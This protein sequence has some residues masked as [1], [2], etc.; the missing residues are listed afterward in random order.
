MRV[1]ICGI[2]NLDDAL[3]AVGNGADALGFNFY[4]KSP[5][6]VAPGKAGEIIADLPPFVTPVGVFVNAS[7]VHIDVVVKLAGLRAIQLHG[8]ESPEACLGHSVPVIRV[9]RVGQDFDAETM[10]SYLVDTFL[11]DTAKTGSYGGTGKTFDWSRAKDAK[12]FGRIILAGGLNPDNV[13]EA[14]DEVAPYAVDTSSGVEI[15]PGKK[16]HEKVRKFLE[17]AKR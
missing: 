3:C 12:A 8:D 14:I 16:D 15:E 13:A 2:T 10:R 6:Y 9:L 11:L 5:R 1:K 17:V 7:E 4:K